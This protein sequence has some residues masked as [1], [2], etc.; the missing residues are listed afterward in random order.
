MKRPPRTSRELL[1]RRSLRFVFLSGAFKGGLG[2]ATLIVMPLFGFTLLAVQTVI[3]QT[4]AI[5]KLVSTYTARGLTT[6]PGRNLALHVAVGLG[7][8]LQVLTMALA[9]IRDLLDL[10]PIDPWAVAAVVGL[11]AIAVVGQRLLARLLGRPLL[12]SLQHA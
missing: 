1:D 6:R 2:I 3:F 9:P 10:E 7:L 8:V 11:V 12:R 4:E 5:G